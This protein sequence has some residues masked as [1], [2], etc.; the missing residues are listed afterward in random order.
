MPK[1]GMLFG[2]SGK[3]TNHILSKN[4]FKMDNHKIV[5]PYKGIDYDVNVTVNHDSGNCRIRADVAGHQIL[6][7]STEDDCLQAVI[8][9]KILDS[10][11]IEK[12]GDRICKECL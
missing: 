3:E 10:G 8:E 11:L 1:R 2:P 6:F 12:I 9:E 5:V 7:V 4:Y